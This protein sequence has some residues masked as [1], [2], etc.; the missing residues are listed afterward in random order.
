MID[1]SAR[2]TP[3]GSVTHRGSLDPLAKLKFDSSHPIIGRN[4][5]DNAT[6]R[7]N[8]S[9]RSKIFNIVVTSISTSP[10]R[11]GGTGPRQRSSPTILFL[12]QSVLLPFDSTPKSN[13]SE[14]FA[15][16]SRKSFPPADNLSRS[17]GCAEATTVKQNDGSRNCPSSFVRNRSVSRSL[18]LCGAR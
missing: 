16:T 9:V 18:W 6:I 2:V 7:K 15:I 1:A 13:C 5:M 17:G 14:F 11:S 8:L 3:G 12:F 10:N 4:E